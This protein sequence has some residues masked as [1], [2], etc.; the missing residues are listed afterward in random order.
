LVCFVSFVFVDTCQLCL[1]CQFY[2]LCHSRKLNFQS[3]QNNGVAQPQQHEP[4]L[5]QIRKTEDHYL[6][7]T[8]TDSLP[9]TYNYTYNYN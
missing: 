6:S 8:T 9:V 1:L 4:L 5:E 3:H 7:C 2:Q